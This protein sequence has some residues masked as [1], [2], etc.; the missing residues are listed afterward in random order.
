MVECRIIP[1]NN[2]KNGDYDFLA[3][4]F[5]GKHSYDTFGIYRVSDGDRYNTELT[6]QMTDKTADIVGDGT[7]FFGTTHKQRVFNINFAFD[8]MN[9]ATLRAMKKWLNDKEIHDLWFD[10][11]PY[12]VY[13]A[14]VTGTATM[15]YVVFE[16]P[17]KSDSKK[18]DRIYKG[19]GSIQFTAYWPYAHTPDF[20]GISGNASGKK[21]TSYNDFKN[22][23]LWAT[24]S[25][26][27]TNDNAGQN[28]GDIPAPFVLNHNP[29]N[30]NGIS[31]PAVEA[32]SEKTYSITEDIYITVGGAGQSALYDLTWDSKT[33]IVSARI[34]DSAAPK[35]PIAYSGNS[36]GGIP[37]GG[38]TPVLNGA[39]LQYHYWYY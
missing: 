19:E 2:S 25:G 15:K 28:P 30:A 13:S 37:V 6:P 24:A 31:V 35:K 36:L 21:I 26:L 34:G 16:E 29:K 38:C 33:G 12:K 39:T 8:H 22:K 1:P 23:D 9:D 20:V 4:S 5:D 7:F 32:E 18:T 17:N 27:T 10:E 11:E 14:K 3:F